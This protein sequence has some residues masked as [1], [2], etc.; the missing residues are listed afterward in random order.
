MTASQLAAVAISVLALAISIYGIW[1]RDR[2]RERQLRLRLSELVDALSALT[3]EQATFSA[4]NKLTE[5]VFRSFNRRRSVLCD[6]ASTL[7]KETR[8]EAN[9]Q[10]LLQLGLSNARLGNIEPARELFR[11]ATE[12]VPCSSTA[13]ILALREYAYALFF[14]FGDV[15]D[16]RDYFLQAL[17]AA[18]GR[19]DD[20]TVLS[21]IEVRLLWARAEAEVRRTPDMERSRLLIS[22]AE[23]TISAI[24]TVPLLRAAT[25]LVRD[26]RAVYDDL[27]IYHAGLSVNATQRE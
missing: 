26:A 25:R 18:G 9:S 14:V 3:T 4:E 12:N 22:E 11:C 2:D 27:A 21:L 7:L 23:A 5:E 10:Q 13:H 20:G 17:G 16:G 1:E 15:E 8:I 19:D 6:E 24:R